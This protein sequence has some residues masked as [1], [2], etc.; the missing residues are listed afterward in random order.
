MTR[1]SAFFVGLGLVLFTRS[2][3]AKDVPVKNVA[4]LGA[5]ISAAAPGDV[6]ILAP[7][8]YASTGFSCNANGTS[9][10]PIVVKSATPLAARIDFDALEGFKVSGANW[11]F[12]G[13]EVHGV[14]AK[15]DDCEHAFHVTG[16]AVGF[17][18]RGNKLVDFNAQLKVNANKDSGG[19]WLMPHDGLLENN[20]VFD[21][22]PRN[23]S[24]P[25]T[26]F[27][28]DTG[29]RW[30]VRGNYIHDFE[31]DGG[32]G[33]SYGSFMKSG[34]KNG[35]YERN[36]VV[37]STG[38]TTG[39]R[40]GLSFGGGGTA[41][42]FCFPAFDASVPCSVEHDGGTMRNNIIA[43]CSDVGIYINRGKATKLLHNTLIATS[44]IDF[45]F[46]TTTGEAHG[47]LLAG[48]IRP[49]DGG[50]F[51]GT[52][53]LGDQ[54]ASDFAA[55]YIDP[56][57][58]DLRLKGTLTALLGKVTTTTV[59]DDYCGR[60]RGASPHDYGALESSLGDCPTLFGSVMPPG[61]SGV[62]DTGV[63]TS[64]GGVPETDSGSALDGGAVDDGGSNPATASDESSGCGCRTAGRDRS[65]AWGS[66]LLLALLRRRR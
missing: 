25:T 3:F 33:V 34:G 56:T 2:A 40:I 52:D 48:K 60:M 5:A 4:E 38:P 11:H 45:R 43:S 14:C 22:R 21:T 20:E 51:S 13:L 35:V 16:G 7:G 18:L 55:W 59:T 65:F 19:T 58:G 36:L 53:N 30:I 44:G 32:D 27:N 57:K 31:K 8:T 28:I 66:L 62:T 15:D 37:C 6:I 47:N 63:P 23:T 9:E 29:D 50:T 12:E 1:A 64:D 17:V 41:P 49:R 26:K 46:D 10:N 42:Q 24:N 39:T 61:D 54:T